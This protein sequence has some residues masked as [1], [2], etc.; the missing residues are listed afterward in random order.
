MAVS[1]SK[2]RENIYQIL[3]GILKT[4]KPVE[5]LR[6]GKKLKIVAEEPI[7]KLQNLVRRTIIRGNP[8]DLVSMDWSK[9]WKWKF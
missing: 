4:G 9:E 2:L 6:K 1:A 5:V 3:D 7:V 8:E